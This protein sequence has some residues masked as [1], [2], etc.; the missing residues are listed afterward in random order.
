MIQAKALH[1]SY[2]GRKILQ[3]VDLYADAGEF[4]SIMGKSGSGK[5]TLLNILAGNL[6]PDSGSVLLDGEDVCSMND[7][8][9]S[10]LRRTKLGFVY[11][12]LNLIPT[13]TAKDNILLPLYLDRKDLKQGREHMEELARSLDVAHLLNSFPSSMS[14]GERQRVA[15]ARAMVH[16]PSVLMLDEPTGSLDNRS[17]ADVMELLCRLNREHGITVIQVTHSEEAAAYGSRIIRL[18]DGQVVEP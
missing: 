2:G 12:S 13:L 18:S 16:R 5:S 6:P 8:R 1:K 7:A 4:L 3:N 17:T 9:L 11:Q 15:I 10:K 14:G